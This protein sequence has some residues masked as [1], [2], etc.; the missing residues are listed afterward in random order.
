M[1]DAVKEFFGYKVDKPLPTIRSLIEA[2]YYENDVA[3][4]AANAE[5]ERAKH[6]K[7][8]LEERKLRLR[9]ALADAMRGEVPNSLIKAD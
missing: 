9:G 8:M 2:E 6:H 3:L 7:A 5:F 4:L 1:L